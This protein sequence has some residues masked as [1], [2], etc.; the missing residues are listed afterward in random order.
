MT[1]YPEGMLKSKSAYTLDEL[2][3][4]QENGIILEH[5]AISCDSEHN[6]HFS[7]GCMRGI[8]PRI[9]CAA[10]I[11]DGSVRD[12]AIL[13]RVG[14][15]TCFVITAFCAES[16]KPY[17]LLSRTE[18]QLRCRT[19]YHDRLLPGDILPCR[20]THLE[21]FGAF[22]DA[23]CGVSALL[24]IDC[25]SV[26]RIASPADRVQT[27]QTLFCAVKG[28]DDK[29]RLVLT[30]KELLGTWEENVSQYR[31]GE[32]VMGIV[33]SVESYGVFVELTPNLAGLAENDR[34]VQP[35][36]AVSVYIKS[37]VPEKM[38]LKLALLHTLE[39]PDAPQPLAYVQTEGH[40]S[41]WRYSPP[42]SSRIIE[43]VF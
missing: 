27:G 1:Y 13:S 36:Q 30:L 19:Q 37:I 9:A 2:R 22:C 39:T 3:H 31:A 24:P 10:G 38:K 17:A 8:M 33:R 23:G 25:M 20:V 7:L 43:T 34:P 35:G 41:A 5:R 18:A 26:S 11:E 4:A 15:Q 28:R 16:G 32:T 40:V 12:I 29:G 21:S 14:R 6:L 42:Q